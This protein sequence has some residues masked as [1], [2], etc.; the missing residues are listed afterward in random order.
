MVYTKN[1]SKRVSTK[2]IVNKMVTSN[3]LLRD[4]DQFNSALKISHV[5]C[6]VKANF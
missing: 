2:K 6:F 3:N 1:H 4:G 5:H